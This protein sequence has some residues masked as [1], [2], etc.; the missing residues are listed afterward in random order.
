MAVVRQTSCP[1]VSISSIGQFPVKVISMT[2]TVNATC[3]TALVEVVGRIG[4]SMQLSCLRL[5]PAR[6]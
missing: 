5:I 1:I 4:V 2:A 6:A 3:T